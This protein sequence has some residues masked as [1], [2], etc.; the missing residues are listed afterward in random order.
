[1][2]KA[3]NNNKQRELDDNRHN[4]ILAAL[5]EYKNQPNPSANK[6]AKEYGIPRTT[7]DRAIKNDS[8]PKRRGPPTVLTEHE[9]NQL[10]GYCINMQKLGFGLTR[11]NVNYV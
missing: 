6:I 7:F 8:P 1:M 9:E 2:P 10:V 4:A 5:T 3:S 11:S